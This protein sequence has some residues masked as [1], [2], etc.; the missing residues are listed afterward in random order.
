MGD[1]TQCCPSYIGRQGE[2]STS[3]EHGSTDGSPF[4]IGILLGPIASVSYEQFLST[5]LGKFHWYITLLQMTSLLC[6]HVSHSWTLV[7]LSCLQE[8]RK[9]W[10]K[11]STLSRNISRLASLYRDEIGEK[12]LLRM[13]KLLASFPYLLR[14]HIRSGCLCSTDPESVDD[15]YKLQLDESCGTY[16]D[17]RY[18]GDHDAQSSMETLGECFVDRRDLPWSLLEDR[19]GETLRRIARSDNRPLWICDRLGFEI[20][21]FNLDSRERLTLLKGIDDL[22]STIGQC[23]RI[24]QT[25]VPLN[26]ARHA[27]RSLTLWLFTLPFCMVKDLG[28]LTGPATGIIAWVLFGIY[29]IGYE[30]EDPFQKSLRLSIFCDAIRRDV[31]GVEELGER[32]SA[33]YIEEYGEE[34]SLLDVIPESRGSMMSNGLDDNPRNDFIM[35]ANEE[36]MSTVLPLLQ[37]KPVLA[38]MQP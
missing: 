6:K 7:L 4:S 27:L 28:L 11:I 33:F 13:K 10:E 35:G 3:N 36:L 38:A 8:G 30:I 18:E 37:Q 15:R 2:G 24:R 22:S 14:H 19:R 21:N 12:K 1:I 9:I 16:I 5:I 25:A 23:E 31:L 34:S 29:Q 26:Y 20:K 32:T 17:S